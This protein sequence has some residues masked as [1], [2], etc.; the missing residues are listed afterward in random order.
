M[1]QT[2]RTPARSASRT[3][4][5]LRSSRA[6]RPLTSSATPCSRATSNTRSR[7][8]AFS[9]RRPMIRPIGWL[10]QR[11]AGWRS[12]SSTRRVSSLARHPL[13]AVHAGLDPVELGE[14]VVGEVEPAV[15]QDVALDPAQDA[16]RRQAL[17]GG[18]DLLALAADVVGGQAAHR[19]H[20]R[21]VVADRDVVVAALARGAAHLLDAEA[22]VGPGRVAVQ[23]AADVLASEE[24]RRLAAE[25]RLA[26]LRRNPRAARAPR[27][28]RPR[29]ARRAA[30]RAP[31]RTPPSRWRAPARCRSARARATT[32]SIGTPSIVNPRARRSS[33]SITA[34]ICGSASKRASTGAGSGSA[35]TT[36]SCSHASR[37]RR[38]SPAGSPSSALA[39]APTSARARS[40]SSPGWRR[41]LP[42]E[43]LRSRAPR[44]FGP[45]P[46]TARSRPAATAAR[47]SSGVRTPS[48]RAISTERFVVSPRKRPRPTSPGTSSRSSSRSSAIS[49]VSTSSRSRAS[50][51]GPMPR[52]SRT[53]PD[54][55]SGSIGTGAARIVSA[56]RR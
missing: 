38:V 6:A 41:G 25:R 2:I 49:P 21:R 1:E 30:A 15:G 12:A 4:S 31:R 7:S 11:T 13:P 43:R 9:G 42:R 23:V 54:R 39:I 32:R 18:G 3:C 24:R 14:D 50:I 45:T 26:Q 51:P 34:T 37:Q 5:P 44:V 16:E 53:R 20:G 27:R 36:A 33:R 17:V 35:Q 29:S 55:T 46:G 10:R 28:R 19:A 22:A 52:S 48:A 56:A 8:S 40:S 47:N